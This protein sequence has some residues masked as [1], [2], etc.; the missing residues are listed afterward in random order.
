M[1]CLRFYTRT[2]LLALVAVLLVGGMMP[3]VAGAAEEEMGLF[4]PFALNTKVAASVASA[5][6]VAIQ[7]TMR[8]FV[9]PGQGSVLRSPPLIVVPGSARVHLRSPIQPGNG[10]YQ[11]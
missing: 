6:T 10:S 7:P 2:G 3:V 1:N 5:P 9:M 4:D 8:P 11:N